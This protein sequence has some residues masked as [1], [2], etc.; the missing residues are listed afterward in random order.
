MDAS[1]FENALKPD[2]LWANY[3]DAI[4]A[5][6]F[7]VLGAVIVLSIGIRIA[8]W[9]SNLV[10]KALLRSSRLDATLGAFFAS[11]V[12]YALM[13][14]VFITALQVFG[15]QA[16]SLVAVLGAATLAIGLALQGTLGG[17]AAGVMIILFRPYKLGDTVDIGGKL[18]TVKDINLFTTM[19]ATPDNVQITIPNGLIWGDTI[20]NYSGFAERRV[21][22]V[23]NIAY[24]D[25]LDRAIGIVETVVADE[26][27]LLRD[28]EHPAPFVKVTN[29]GAFSVDI[30]TR[31]WV[32]AK[33]YWDVRFDLVRAVK[34]AF[35]REGITIPY[36]TQTEYVKPQPPL[37]QSQELKGD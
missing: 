32:L 14:M 21:D 17:V 25:D 2:V 3:G 33:D 7:K 6:G 37:A 22:L 20:T 23:F 5:F 13:V 18:G 24:E 9:L 10:R 12:K 15:V 28:T 8:I 26:V 19:L 36:P 16:T 4:L 29:L 30:T 1:Q 11:I 35:D 31:T 27:R 34:L